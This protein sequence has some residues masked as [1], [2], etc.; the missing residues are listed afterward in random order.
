MTG[1]SQVVAAETHRI[2]SEMNGRKGYIFNLGH[3]LPAG[4][5]IENIAMLVETITQFKW[6]N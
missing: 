1:S 6:V 2:L 4:T 5:P 3:G